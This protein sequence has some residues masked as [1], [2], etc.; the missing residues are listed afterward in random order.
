MISMAFAAVTILGLYLIPD[1]NVFL[2]FQK[3]ILLDIL[4]K[5][6]GLNKSLVTTFRINYL[7]KLRSKCG[8]IPEL[9]NL[10]KK[11]KMLMPHLITVVSKTK[12]TL[13]TC[14]AFGDI[15]QTCTPNFNYIYKQSFRDSTHQKL[16]YRIWRKEANLRW[17]K[18]LKVAGAIDLLHSKRYLKFPT[19]HTLKWKKQ[20]LVKYHW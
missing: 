19:Q 10:L 14:D 5:I 7:L 15:G 4:Y 8:E 18:I 2:L 13:Q 9:D 20:P 11:Y 16:R 6:T 3:T 17:N 12:I 1:V